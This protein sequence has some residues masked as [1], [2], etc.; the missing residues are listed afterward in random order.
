[1]PTI[2]TVVVVGVL[3]VATW[4]LVFASDG[5]ADQPQIDRDV[6]QRYESIDGVSATQTTIVSQNGTVTSR[7]TYDATLQP[8]TQ[9]RRLVLV[10]STSQA[11][12]VRISDGSTLWL[13]N[14]SRGR[15]TRIPLSETESDRGERL[16]RL[17]TKLDEST[18]DPRSVEPLPVVPRGERRPV[19]STEG[20]T[21]SYRGTEPVDGREAYVVHVTPRNGTKAYEQTV[22]VDTQ[23][24]FPAKQ[25][26]AWTADEKHTVVTTRFANVTYD[27]G[28][29]HDEFAPDFPDDTAVSVPEPS[30]RRFYLRCQLCAT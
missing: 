29:P 4:S 13:Y 28:V 23:R 9:K 24:F 25:R 22:W 3:A 26:T 12:D 11:N 2:A 6:Q 20:M 8:G 7:I 1:M 18:A 15:A 10:N 21:V 30:D 5:A 14:D 17:F 19:N 27:T 16:Q